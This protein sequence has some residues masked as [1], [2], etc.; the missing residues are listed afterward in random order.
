MR[1]AI[2]IATGAALVA[3]APQLS[4]AAPVSRGA[5]IQSGSL[6]EGVTYYRRDYD[7]YPRHRYYGYS[8]YPRHRYY[9]SY[10]YDDY[11]PR[12][13]YYQRHYYRPYYQQYYRRYWY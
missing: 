3:L 10:D 1:K 13:Y 9:R 6:A 4:S 2:L 7:Y 11:S 12:R 8:Y 5:A